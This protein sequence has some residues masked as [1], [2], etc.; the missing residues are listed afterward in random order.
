MKGVFRAAITAPTTTVEARYARL[1]QGQD[2]RG[3]HRRRSA[4]RGV[5]GAAASRG[6]VVVSSGSALTVPS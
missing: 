4:S 5:R 3:K 1:R 2:E 6:G